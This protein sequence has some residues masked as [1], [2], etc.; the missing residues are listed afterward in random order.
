TPGPPNPDHRYQDV[1]STETPL[2]PSVNRNS[3][4]IDSILHRLQEVTVLKVL[5]FLGQPD[6]IIQSYMDQHFYY[7]TERFARW[8]A[9]EVLGTVYAYWQTHQVWLQISPSDQRGKRWYSLLAEDLSPLVSKATYNLAVMLSGYQSRVG[10]VHSQYSIRDFPIDIQNFTDAVQQA[11]LHQHQLAVL[12]QGE[13]G[14]GKTAWAQAVAKEL[15]S[16][17]GYVVFVL[18]HD[19]VEHFMPPTYLER[20]CLIINEADNLAKNRALEVA[21]NNNKTEHILSLLD[22]TSYQS[23]IDTTGIQSQQQ[24]VVLMT[25]NTAERLDPAILRKGRIDLTYEFTHR[26]V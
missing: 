16:P 22:G 20:I 18:D 13:P 15:L 14:T 17:L 8:E 19:A 23:V 10:Q 12:V 6:F 21:Q 4:P 5:G 26:F 24:L 3:I 2:K 1:L 11:V 9:L 7:P 25:C